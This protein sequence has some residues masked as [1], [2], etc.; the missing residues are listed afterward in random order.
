MSPRRKR[1]Y[2]LN[3]EEQGFSANMQ[4]KGTSQAKEPVYTYLSFGRKSAQ[5]TGNQ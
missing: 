4:E 2:V 5:M 3:K 1:R